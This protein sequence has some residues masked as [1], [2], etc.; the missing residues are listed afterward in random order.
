[1]TSSA[2]RRGR[3]DAAIDDLKATSESIQ[4]DAH[5]LEKI[6]EEKL[7]LTPDDEKLTGLSVEAVELAE[8][9]ERKAKAERQ[10]A[11]EVE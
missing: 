8:R 7:S 3:R 5:E 6:E 9:I 4:A 1:M 11:S 10:I 2:D